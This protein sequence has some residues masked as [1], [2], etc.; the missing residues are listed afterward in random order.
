MRRLAI[1]LLF[2]LPLA[3][4]TQQN[5]VRTLEATLPASGASSLLTQTNIGSV[6]IKP[7]PDA[8]V[9]ISV[10]LR[11]SSNFLWGL[12]AHHDTPDTIKAASLAHNLNDHT[13]ELSVQYPEGADTGG[14]NE[15]WTVAVPATFG[16]MSHI[17]IGKLHVTGTSGGVAAQINI[18]KVAL[19]VPGG[20]LDVTINVGKIAAQAHTLAYG[21]VALAANVGNTSLTV[22]GLSVG[23]AQ[24]E[25]AGS[26]MSYHGKGSDTINLKV[27]TGKATLA[28]SAPTA[29]KP[30]A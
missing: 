4:C 27:N 24:K 25:G 20:P 1:F 29:T 21:D 15:T 11:P 10:G 18:G 16:V 23:D 19:D 30:G 28:L 22:D 17:N 8:E 6:T 7:S 14:V 13:L 26:Q 5:T 3:A 12:I 2:L 9:H